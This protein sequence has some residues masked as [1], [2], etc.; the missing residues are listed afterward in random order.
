MHNQF[1]RTEMY[2]QYMHM[3]SPIGYRAVQ[4]LKYIHRTISEHMENQIRTIV[5]QKHYNRFIWE[6]IER[7]KFDFD[8]K[9]V[10]PLCNISLRVTL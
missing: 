8:M 3:N 10:S 7:D 4:Q 6:N 9:Q 5:S 2:M 1:D